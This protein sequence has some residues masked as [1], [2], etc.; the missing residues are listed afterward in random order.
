MTHVRVAL[1]AL[2][3]LLAACGGAGSGGTTAP[4]PG[5]TAAPAVA[6]TEQ[7]KQYSPGKTADP[8]ASPDGYYG[9]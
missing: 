4:T 9:Y 2:A 7:P 5:T 3:I 1:F 6:G 8:S